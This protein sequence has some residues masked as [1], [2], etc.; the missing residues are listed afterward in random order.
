MYFSHFSVAGQSWIAPFTLVWVGRV[1]HCYR[2]DRLERWNQITDVTVNNVRAWEKSRITYSGTHKC[3]RLI[4][5]KTLNFC[6]TG[7]FVVLIFLVCA[8]LVGSVYGVGVEGEGGWGERGVDLM[9]VDLMSFTCS[10][11]RFHHFLLTPTVFFFLFLK[12]RSRS[13]R[14]TIE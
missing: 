2:G 6:F 12:N 8:R 5:K 4:L 7:V 1:W 14:V 9:R 3:Q 11:E 10:L 13:F